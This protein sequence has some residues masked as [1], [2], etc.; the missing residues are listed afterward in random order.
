MGWWD[1]LLQ[2]L[3][4]LVQTGASIY[5]ANQASNAARQQTHGINAGIDEQ[6]RQFDIIMQMLAPQQQ[7]GTNAL[8]TLN[9]LY[10]YGSV[11]PQATPG[12]G[13]GTIGSTGIGVS[14]SGGITQGVQAGMQGTGGIV[15]GADGKPAHL[16]DLYPD[17]F[18]DLGRN[19]TLR[20]TP[21]QRAQQQAWGETHPQGG[22]GGTLSDIA[23]GVLDIAGAAIPAFGLVRAGA[24]IGNAL[25][26]NGQSNNGTGVGQT[27]PG[28]GGGGYSPTTPQTQGS[29]D[30]SVFFNSPDY[31]FR[32]TE[33]NRDIG[34]SFAARG[35]ALSGNALRGITDY[36][37]NLAS[38]E[39]NNFVQRQLQMAGL[40]GAAT[41]Q[42]VNAAQYTGGNVSNLLEA[43]GNA[44]A[45]GVV[46]RTNA[47]T[48]GVNELAN[49]YGNW[50]RNRNPST[51]GTSWPTWGS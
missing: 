18:R 43:G 2:A 33:G 40:G 27:N 19:W 20:A 3:P 51:T 46:D 23:G 29:P 7:L 35:G 8:N 15:M 4:A 22:L 50:S 49:W 47:I 6:R 42:G 45:S 10:G 25:L 39:F 26:Q 41:S 14:G 1:G 37:S 13:S 16:R 17:Q 11:S 30:M 12:Q 24:D 5:G 31:N 21:E 32:R 36:N 9:R 38:G 34:N 28:T 44:R 48:N